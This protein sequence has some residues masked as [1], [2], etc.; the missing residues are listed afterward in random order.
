MDLLLELA[1]ILSKYPLKSL[2]QILPKDSK[3]R[4]LFDGVSKGIIQSDE[5]ASHFLYE[6]APS[7]K[8]YL[9]LKRNLINKLFELLLSNDLEVEK[10]IRKSKR[11]DIFNQEET[12]LLSNQYLI[13]ADKLLVQNVYHNAEKIIERV[14]Q[15]AK[16]HHLIEIEWECVRK[17]RTIYALK[18]F[19]NETEKYTLE[20]QELREEMI[21]LDNL[22]SY[23]EVMQAKTKFFIGQYSEWEAEAY[24]AE[25][26]SES[27][28][29]IENDE[30]ITHPLAQLY[31][32]RFR[33]THLLQSQ[34]K[35]EEL[36][37]NTDNWQKHFQTYPHL[38]TPTRNLELLIAQIYT[39]RYAGEF[40]QALQL[41]KKAVKLTTY[42][43]FNKFKI[44]EL[45]FDTLLKINEPKHGYKQAALILLEV[46]ETPQFERLDKW[47]K[48][49][50]R[51]REAYL[52]LIL[53]DKDPKLVKKFTP[54]F[55]RKNLLLQLPDEPITKDKTGYNIVR[56][57]IKVLFLF[58]TGMEDFV[59]ESN[60]FRNYYQ[61]HLKDSKD[62]RLR[63]FVLY[64]IKLAQN[65]FNITFLEEN[66]LEL[67]KEH[68][69]FTEFG[70]YERM[71][72]LILNLCK[73]VV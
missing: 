33:N 2:D 8:R 5:E 11:K 22:K 12:K 65:D 68:Y 45:Y 49:S 44:Q 20:A 42:Q 19:A 72:E 14:R 16:E 38:N 17:L 28:S 23:W 34:P 52:F 64:L 24:A 53:Q 51:L 66:K 46:I 67:P 13:I 50:W 9:M 37:K 63:G 73:K 36:Q 29:K 70:C 41:I 3:M 15:K 1:F 61:R 57:W 43:A 48:S 54:N 69:N 7:D 32:F 39:H 25:K 21:F 59:S 4:K 55:Y 30:K 26:L 58:Y 56:I 40:L 31:G 18:G 10:K 6:T 35:L 60:N 71:E 27:Y 62:E 47:D